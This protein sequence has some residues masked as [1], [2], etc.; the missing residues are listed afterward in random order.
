MHFGFGVFSDAVKFAE[1]VVGVEA[2]KVDIHSFF[3]ACC[4][5]FR[6]ANNGD[7]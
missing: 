1:V 7:M 3:Q 2:G 4:P 6:T 5:I